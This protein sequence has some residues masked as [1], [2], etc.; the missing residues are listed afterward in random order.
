MFHD[1]LFRHNSSFLDNINQH[2]AYS[3]V[4]GNPVTSGR[5][6]HDITALLPDSRG[7]YG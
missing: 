4:V 6:P 7:D 5:F 2:L 1:L 3:L